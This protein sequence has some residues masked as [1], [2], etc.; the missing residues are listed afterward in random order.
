MYRFLII[1]DEPVVREGISQTI[2]W[3]AHGFELVGACGDGREGMEAVEREK[4]DVVLTDICMPFV[5]GLELAGA[6]AEEHPQTRTILLTGYDEFEYAQEAVK[7]KVRDFLLKPITP[8]ELRDLLTTL[9][10]ELDAEQQRRRQ[11]EHV[12]EQ[13]RES[14]PLLRERFLNRLVR[15]EIAPEEIE[16]RL[17]LLDLELPGPSYVA[18]VC[19]PDGAEGADAASDF[20]GLGLQR[21]IREMSADYPGAIAFSTAKE[22]SVALLSGENGE[23]VRRNALS[24]AEAVAER[25]QTELDDTVSVGIGEPVT[26]L[27]LIRDSYRD[28]HLALEQRL[29]L[30]PN[31]V[32]TVDQI[33][34]LGSHGLGFHFRDARARFAHGLKT[35]SSTDARGALQEIFAACG[36]AGE[37]R[38]SCSIIFHRLLADTLEALDSLGVTYQEIADETPN[39]FERLEALKTLEE[40][41]RWFIRL[42][43]ST[44][45]AMTRRRRAHSER[46][47]VA[48][49]EYI[50][51]NYHRRDLSLRE[52][53][54]TLSISK[55]YF[56][57][58]FKSHTGMTFVEYLTQLRME[59]A[60][61][62]LATED[63]MGYE[64]AEEVGFKNAH[65]FSLTFKKQTGLSPTEYRE[66]VRDRGA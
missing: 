8:R 3:H 10:E 11:Q 32:I 45:S 5:D 7:L 62:L 61:E 24:F 41:E 31:H 58:I 35:G 49:E 36:Q 54:S 38:D 6:I 4:P 56:S 40:M 46:K 50:R 1:D 2:D 33:R 66:H 47:A 44:R 20:E 30:G 42:E 53:C 26:E 63:L 22:E 15:S 64:I 23:A 37:S 29:V 16:R 65:Y 19:D 13:I 18:L 43:E 21:I 39:P 57:P 59:R 25:A 14:L 48:A 52:L 9:R 17:T 55:S 28:A 34:G 27:E 12:Q 51:D 60:K